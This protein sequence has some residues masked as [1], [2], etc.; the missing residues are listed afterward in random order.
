M[1]SA[2]MRRGVRARPCSSLPLNAVETMGIAANRPGGT[3]THR[4]WSKRKGRTIWRT[5]ARRAAAVVPAPPWCINAAQRGSSVSWH[6][7]PSQ[8]LTVP[9]AAA[10]RRTHACR[11]GRQPAA[12]HEGGGQSVEGQAPSEA[13]NHLVGASE[14]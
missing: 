8:A 2:V 1:R 6:T 12:A 11:R 4:C 14:P 10:P 3:P 9:R 5:P 13:E 7:M